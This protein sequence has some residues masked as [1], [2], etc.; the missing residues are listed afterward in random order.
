MRF[1]KQLFVGIAVAAVVIGSAGVASAA[2][3]AE[4]PVAAPAD[5]P[6]QVN[7]KLWG[8]Y[9]FEVQCLMSRMFIIQLGGRASDCFQVSGKWY[10]WDY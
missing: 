8:P 5:D 4:L 6:V 9:D 1:A 3:T 2:N 10:F 7:L